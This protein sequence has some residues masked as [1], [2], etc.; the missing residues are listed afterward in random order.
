[1]GV[2][3]TFPHPRSGPAALNRP[4]TTRRLSLRAPG[5]IT[6]ILFTEKLKRALFAIWVA[7]R[8]LFKGPVRPLSVEDGSPQLSQF[9][10]AQRPVALAL[11]LALTRIYHL[12]VAYISA[13][14]AISSIQPSPCPQDCDS[15]RAEFSSQYRF[16]TVD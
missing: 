7:S 11:S 9:Y 1:M 10:P 12:A 3:G 2:K 4:R 5:C 13:P 14:C 16:I 15:Q 8:V 6:L